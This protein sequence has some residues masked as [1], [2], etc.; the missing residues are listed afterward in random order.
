MSETPTRPILLSAFD[1]P[2]PVHQSPGLWRH[3]EDR[4][5]E[6]T[7]IDYWVHLARTLEQGGFH[8]LFFADVLGQYDVY[9]GSADEAVRGGV[10]YPLLDPTV[11]V[12]ALAQAT[13]RLGFGV[14]ASTG[15]EHPYLLARR[16][17]TLDHVTRGRLAWNIV[18]SYQDSAARNLGLGR[19]LGHDARYDRAEEY[20]EVLY[21]LWEGTFDDGAVRRDRETGVYTDPAGVHGAGHDGEAFTVPGPALVEP[22]PQRTPLLFQA[23]ASS[24]G[25][26]FAARHAEAIF[27]IGHT[28]EVVAQWVR[29]IRE[30][31]AAAGRDPRS[32]KI[33]AGVTVV[34]DRTD[35]AARARLESYRP[36]VDV[37][38]AL[39]LFAG[40]TGVD[41][42]T[43][44]PDAPL[45]HAV[46]DANQ[47][48]LAAFTKLDAQARWTPRRLAE[49]VGIGGRGPV[50]TGSGATVADELERWVAE[51]DVDGF[52]IISA[53]RPADTESFVR[54]VSPELFRR[55][56][57]EPA[58]A[59]VTL[60]ETFSGA[61][62]TLPADH[63]GAGYRRTRV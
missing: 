24:R 38:A 51:A 5:T 32:V 40:W 36:Y 33:L 34:A 42:S 7:D 56:L 59:G 17:S 10:Q 16:L 26:R 62:P 43:A 55:G 54:R 30:Q 12:A 49:F 2:T 31:V 23:G 3:P 11:L 63:H 19:Q 1:M 39:A 48:A 58:T 35:E 14:T 8:N 44:D 6:Y 29:T 52:N 15:Y 50:I 25:Q 46:T 21:R 45:E 47:S 60:R 53:V 18:T 22:S 27:L 13:T 28:P 41:L 57:L 37:A 4:S 9:R 20:L 61:G